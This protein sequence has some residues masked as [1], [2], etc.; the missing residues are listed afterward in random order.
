MDGQMDAEI[1]NQI[2][3]E[4]LHQ[5]LSRQQTDLLANQLSTYLPC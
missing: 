3:P 4:I 2:T 5:K 1:T